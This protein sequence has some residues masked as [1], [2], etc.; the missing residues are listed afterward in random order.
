LEKPGHLIICAECGIQVGTGHVMRCLALAQTWKRAGGA[1]TFL[2]REGLAGIEERIHAEGI[3]L[4]RLPKECGQSPEAFV[5]VVLGLGSTIAVLDGYRFG[6]S[7]QAVLSGAGIDV[8]TVDDYGHATDYPVRW[9]LNQNAYAAPE[10]YAR[11]NAQLLL[12]PSYALLR[13]EF[14]PWIGW[15]RSIPDRARKILITIGGSDPDNASEQVLRSL[16]FL[17]RN[18]KDLEVVLVVGSGNPHWAS[19]E[20]AGER[21]TVPVRIARSVQDMPALM[22]WADVAIAG[23]GVTSYE[24]CYMGLPSLLLI[25]AENQRRIAERL[26]E[27][28]VAV[29]AG[30]SREFRGEV[31]AGQLQ[32]LM[33]SS[34]R[35]GAMSHGGRALVDGLGS[36]RVRA[37]LLDR[38]LN[39]RLVR[40][41]DSRRLFEL[42]D[43][44]VVR[45]ASFHSAAISWEEHVRWFAERLQD[46]RSVIYLGENAAGDVVGVVR[47]QIK[48]ESA[49]L[50]VNVAP[51]FRGR[52]WGRELIAFSTRTLVRTL[53]ASTFPVRRI[54]AFVK[55]D[56]QASVRLFETSGFRRA[57]RQRVAD[58][59]ALLF[60]WE[61]GNGSHVN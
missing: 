1:V 25:I 50:S 46:R 59:D 17:E 42:A 2:L 30:T 32:A 20:A 39:L 48:G 5:R 8:L 36:E 3:L 53:A 52:G 10:M 57:G 40:Q 60:T 16:E 58:Q 47:F 35:R 44:P 14:L 21:C 38:K 55:P 11:T 19:L 9:V 12:G 54:D 45:A 23:A 24:L 27:L 41:S 31:F 18:N 6:A 56:N 13:D 15:K 49:A 43:D 29:N 7:E 28:G 34:E 51:E 26:S 61:C 22:A 37:A 4:E 33:D